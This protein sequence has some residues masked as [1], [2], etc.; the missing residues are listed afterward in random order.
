VVIP[1]EKRLHEHLA[2][3]APQP[4]IDTK[5]SF[6]ARYDSLALNLRSSAQKRLV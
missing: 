5:A 4:S 1:N 3:A 6:T 2:D